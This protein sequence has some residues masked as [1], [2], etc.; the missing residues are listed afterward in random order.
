MIAKSKNNE[1]YISNEVKHISV[2]ALGA[3]EELFNRYLESVLEY[4]FLY[5]LM[6]FLKKLRLCAR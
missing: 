3:Q 5:E 4:Q 1:L 6:L 2:L